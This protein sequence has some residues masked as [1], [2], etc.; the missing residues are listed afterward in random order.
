MQSSLAL[1]DDIVLWRPLA[2]EILPLRVTA[3]HHDQGQTDAFCMYYCQ[4]RFP[5][6]NTWT[7]HISPL[8]FHAIHCTCL[9]LLEPSLFYQYLKYWPPLL[10]LHHLQTLQVALQLFHPITDKKCWI[11]QGPGY[12]TTALYTSVQ[13]EVEPSWCELIYQKYHLAHIV[14]CY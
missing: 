14:P 3:C 13:A 8:K 11:A 2:K 5:T 9:G 6:S 12:S 7:L 1:T 10:I 4:A